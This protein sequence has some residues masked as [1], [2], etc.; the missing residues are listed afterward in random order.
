MD[1]ADNS[2]THIEASLSESI[3]E[4]RRRPTM[5]PIGQ[6]YNCGSELHS[7]QLFCPGGECRED[8][9]MR[10]KMRRY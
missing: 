6:C 2:D 10:V 9:E 5:K 3:A 7:D 4:V 1:I 8:Y